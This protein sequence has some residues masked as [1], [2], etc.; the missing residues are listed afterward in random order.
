MPR[1]PQWTPDAILAQLRTLGAHHGT[2]LTIQQ[3]EHHGYHPSPAV[4]LNAFGQWRTAWKAAGFTVPEWSKNPAPHT[5][6]TRDKAI[7]ALQAAATDGV[8]LSSTQWQRE[9]HHPT[10]KTLHRWWPSYAAAIDAAGLTLP[11][12]PVP[13]QQ[14]TPGAWEAAW[15]RLTCQLGHPPSRKEWDA[16]P[17][18]PVS[19][20]ILWN[21]LPQASPRARDRQAYA[22]IDLNTI[23]NPR[24]RAWVIA[25]REGATLATIAQAAGVS[26]EWVRYRLRK[27]RTPSPS[28]GNL[29]QQAT[30]VVQ[31]WLNTDPTASH[32]PLY[33]ILQPMADVPNLTAWQRRTRWPISRLK[34][35]LATLTAIRD[36]DT[37]PTVLAT[38]VWDARH[39]MAWETLA[40]QSLDLLPDLPARVRHA[41]HQQ[42]ITTIEAFC[43][44]SVE[45]PGSISG[46]GVRGESAMQ[47]QWQ[48]LQA[49]YPSVFASLSQAMLNRTSADPQT[50]QASHSVTL[51][52][53]AQQCLDTTPR[54]DP[55]HWAQMTVKDFRALQAYL[56]T[57]LPAPASSIESTPESATIRET[58]QPTVP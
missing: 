32:H 40:R 28:P 54:S 10:L 14:P 7:A 22:A 47:A 26:Q 50:S 1:S 20:H 42:G 13:P 6:W 4:I 17:E 51:S 9:H 19:S 27:I 30:S 39:P 29:Y 31:H 16:W 5:P 23:T 33:P 58:L 11:P 35:L 12:T 45:S 3:W 37:I 18:R 57:P 43:A 25:Y 34:T 8:A 24:D 2:W 15:E 41:L 44:L 49:S 48:R 56:R 21:T 36:W 38:L 52:P 46:I 55:E 53:L